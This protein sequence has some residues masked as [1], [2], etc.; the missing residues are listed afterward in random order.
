[1]T[2]EP[3]DPLELHLDRVPFA[4][5]SI[6][7]KWIEPNLA[8]WMDRLTAKYRSVICMRYGLTGFGVH[9]LDE[10]GQELGLTRQRIQQIED[11][12]ILLLR[13]YSVRRYNTLDTLPQSPHIP[14]FLPHVPVGV[15][16]KLRSDSVLNELSRLAR[17]V[18]TRNVKEL[19]ETYAKHF[20]YTL[21]P[22]RGRYYFRDGWWLVLQLSAWIIFDPKT[23]PTMGGEPDELLLELRRIAIR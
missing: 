9:K 11:H 15:Q 2:S 6:D 8:R 23:V 22:G 16:R 21:L 4:K 14:Q 18:R 19:Y 17:R 1:M 13:A 5:L 10:I 12:S 20:G 3:R 7:P